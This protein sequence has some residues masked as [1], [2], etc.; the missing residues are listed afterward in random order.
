M[1]LEE[2]KTKAVQDA[3][4]KINKNKTGVGLIDILFELYGSAFNEGSTNLANK[5]AKEIKEYADNDSEV[6]V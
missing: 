5:V 4:Y 6:D 1:T 2:I 3:A